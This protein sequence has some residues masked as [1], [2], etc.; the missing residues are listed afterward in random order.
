MSRVVRTGDPRGTP[1]VQPPPSRTRSESRTAPASARPRERRQTTPPTSARSP[2]RP[3]RVP[4]ATR[5]A[6]RRCRTSSR[7]CRRLATRRT[8]T[9]ATTCSRHSAAAPGRS[10][11]CHR[12]AVDLHLQ[13]G[14]RRGPRAPRSTPYDVKVK[15]NTSAAGGEDGGPQQRPRD[16]ARARSTGPAPSVRAACS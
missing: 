14:R 1:P 3:R 10:N 11:S 2:S 8:A 16:R 7:R 5:R 9:T 15:R 4:A 13:R 6:R 12:P